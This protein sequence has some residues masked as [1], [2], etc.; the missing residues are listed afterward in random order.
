MF[1]PS[2]QPRD[3]LERGLLEVQAL[4]ELSIALHR[5]RNVKE[6][7]IT[8]LDGTC[9]DVLDTVCELIDGAT[10]S[11]DMVHA[12]GPSLS[13]QA[14]RLSWAEHELRRAAAGVKVRLLAVPSRLDGDFVRDQLRSENPVEIRVAAVPPLQALVVDGRTALVVAGPAG[15]GRVSLIRAPEVVHA[16]RSLFRGVWSGAT[17]ASDGLVFGERT[18]LARRILGA[19]QRGITDEAAA[20]ELEVSVRTYGRHVAEIM[21]ALGASSRSQAGARAAKLGFLT[22]TAETQ[23]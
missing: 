20:R 21:A 15:G 10:H 6:R 8:R 3:E 18:A 13:A 14:A 4:I 2:V 5:D 12:R 11:I 23:I 7:L 22:A 1:E 9:A 19:L 16:M 17:P